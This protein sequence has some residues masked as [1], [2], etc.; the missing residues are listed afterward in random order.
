MDAY[1]K[2]ESPYNPGLT[3]ADV[4]PDAVMTSGSGVDPLISIANA[5]IQA[6]RVAAERHVPLDRVL[7]LIDDHT[8]AAASASSGSR[9]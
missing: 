3:G 6:N 1:L 9:E 7:A 2:L 8:T 5:G 4:P